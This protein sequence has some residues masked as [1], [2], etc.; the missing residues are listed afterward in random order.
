M[1][2]DPTNAVTEV[3]PIFGKLT[4]HAIP[5]Y[6]PVILVAFIGVVILSA[7]VLYLLTKYK[8]WG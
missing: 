7:A 1:A 5:L 2:I 3:S 8:W 6:E 4:W